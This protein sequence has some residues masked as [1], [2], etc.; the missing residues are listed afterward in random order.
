MSERTN[1]TVQRKR[2]GGPEGLEVVE[3]RG[4]I[5]ELSAGVSGS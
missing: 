5:D 3:A 4:E 2:F 1:R